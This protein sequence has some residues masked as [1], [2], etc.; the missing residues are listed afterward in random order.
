MS[1]ADNQR[2]QCELGGNCSDSLDYSFAAQPEP[3]SGE[4]GMTQFV[5]C[6]FLGKVE[7]R[8]ESWLLLVVD[9][10]KHKESVAELISSNSQY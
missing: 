8:L 5:K 3:V 1:S 7:R 6:A 4:M 2:R 9:R 10:N